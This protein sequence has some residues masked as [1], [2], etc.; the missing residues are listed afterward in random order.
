MKKIFNLLTR[1]EY[2]A[3]KA[4]YLNSGMSERVFYNL[5]KKKEVPASF[6][7]MLYD[8]CGITYDFKTDTISRLDGISLHTSEE[9]DAELDKYL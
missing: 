2:E 9:I 6:M 1:L 4:H 8:S 5:K 7:K 3:L